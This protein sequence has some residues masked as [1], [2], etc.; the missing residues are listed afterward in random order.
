[1]I[2]WLFGGVVKQLEV[3]AKNVVQESSQEINNL[4]E[5]KLYPL[6]DKL[7][8]VSKQRIQE[9]E[10]LESQ[11]KADI[12][13]LLNTANEKVK[14]NLEQIDKLRQ[15]LVIDLQETTSKTDFYLENRLN[16]MSLAVMEAI[17]GIDN[18]LARV[19]TLE[20]KLFQDASQIVDKIDEAIDG[21]LE[22]I[23]NELKKLL[24]HT[25]PNPLDKCRQRLSITWKLGSM[26]SDI[27]LYELSECYELSKLNE[28]TLIDDVLKIYGQLQQNA[29][30]MAALVK[31]SPELRHRAIQDWLKY[32]LLC[33]FW[34]STM[35]SYDAKDKL[36]LEPNYAQQLL[37]GNQ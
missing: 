35:K 27:E 36:S 12:E 31:N 32:G 29:S 21:K 33:E 30:M 8:Y 24:A 20:H 26:L 15:K 7:D 17:S 25:L 2:G 5:Q 14:N 1:M 9:T 23:R 13:Q 16:Q 22:F 34:R 3:A 37:T 4:F 19:D 18:S 11:T 28:N 6:A 10:K